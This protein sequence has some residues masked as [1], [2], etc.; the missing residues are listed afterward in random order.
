MTLGIILFLLY[1]N[2]R[3]MVKT[4]I[5]TLAVPFPPG[6]LWMVYLLGL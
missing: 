6:A 1:F 3:S 2:T 4:A 5:I